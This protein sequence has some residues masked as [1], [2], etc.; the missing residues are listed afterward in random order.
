MKFYEVKL[1]IDA[2][3]CSEF[4]TVEADARKRQG[5]VYAATF[6]SKPI[7]THEVKA[8]RAEVALLL[9]IGMK[10]VGGHPNGEML[11]DGKN[12]V[13]PT[14][15]DALRQTYTGSEGGW[16]Y[17]ELFAPT[18]EM[19]LDGASD[20]KRVWGEYAAEI[21]SCRNVVKFKGDEWIAHVRRRE[22][23]VA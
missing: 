22:E 23:K 10:A 9:N 19:A 18:E 20:F 17:Y 12:F 14:E 6:F 5:Q 2:K 15:R 16:L 1:K 11:S 7:I 3:E 4:F 21:K 8:S 13:D